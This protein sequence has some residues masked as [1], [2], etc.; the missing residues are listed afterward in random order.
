MTTSNI[1]LYFIPFCTVVKKKKLGFRRRMLRVDLKLTWVSLLV[2]LSYG[3]DNSNMHTF[4]TTFFPYRV[5]NSHNS[6]FQSKVRI[7]L[8]VYVNVAWCILNTNGFTLICL[9][10]S[11]HV[12]LCTIIEQNTFQLLYV[13]NNVLFFRC[14]VFKEQ[15]IRN[16]QTKQR[17]APAILIKVYANSDVKREKDF[18]KL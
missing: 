3:G 5:D 2:V 11:I 15:C 18:F 17:T 8:S 9:V 6:Y 14:R 13:I 16:G 4:F 10:D 1:P 12:L 7:M